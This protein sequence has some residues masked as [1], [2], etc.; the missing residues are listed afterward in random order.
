MIKHLRIRNFAIIE[1]VSVDFGD[2]LNII[3]GETGAGKSIVIQAISLA[4]GARADTAYIRS[5]CDKALV[6]MSAALDGRDV[7]ISRELSASGRNICRINGDTVTLSELSGLCRRLA[8]IHGQYDHQSLLDPARHMDLI[9]LFARDEIEPLKKDVRIA[10]LEYSSVSRELDDIIRG[11]ADRERRKDF[12]AYELAEIRAADPKPGED[13]QL[14]ERIPIM[15]NSGRIYGSLEEAYETLDGEL[16]SRMGGISRTLEEIAPYSDTLRSLAERV[17]DIYYSMED[18][19]R[20][21]R[22]ERDRTVFQPEELDA[23]IERLDTINGLKKKYGNSIEEILATASELEKEL[24]YTEDSEALRRELTEKKE[25]LYERLVN[26]SAKLTEARKRAASRLTSL[27]LAELADLNFRDARLDTSF[28]TV[29]FS[30]EGADRAE[31]MIS[32]NRGEDLKPLAKI[33]SGGEMS[34]IMLAFKKITGDYDHIP[35]MIFDEIDSGISGITAS[36]VAGKMK[37]IA[38]LHQIICI[39]HLPQIAAAGDHNYS[40]T[41]NVSDEATFTDILPLDREGKIRDIAR[42]LG[43]ASITGTTLRSAEELIE[44]SE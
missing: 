44:A 23:A 25:R 32:T 10:W 41:K 8:D 22:L 14:D 37:Q 11:A 9:D 6:E 7:V 35:T 26:I 3:T 38:G 20:D 2:G 40:I 1:D 18:I 13:D 39:T 42:L 15:E 31:F 24:S 16:Y 33:A 27:I 17:A 29:P 43:G 36:V 28:E 30:A 4:L 34:R 19:S 21:L 12:M 5:G